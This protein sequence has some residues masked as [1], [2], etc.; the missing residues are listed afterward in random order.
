M[1]GD[2]VSGDVQRQPTLWLGEATSAM[3]EA[4]A[5]GP[6]GHQVE[7]RR[8]SGDCPRRTGEVLS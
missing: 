1:A 3:E 2:A 6:E 8:S 7:L 4:V 5:E